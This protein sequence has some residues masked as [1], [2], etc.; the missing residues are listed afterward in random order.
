MKVPA[1]LG[2]AVA[3]VTGIFG[4]AANQI[5]ALVVTLLAARWLTPITF[6]EYSIAA[7]LITLSRA[8]LYA[9]AYEFLLKAP[10]GE[11][12]NTECLIVNVG[13]AAGLGGL[14][15]LLALF[16]GAIFHSTEVGFLLVVLAPSS[17]LSAAANW[18][19]AQML[20]A[21]RIKTYYGVT[22]FAEVAAA[23]VTI[24]MI[25]LGFGLGALVA[26]I[27]CRLFTLMVTYRV[28]Q[29]PIWSK[30][31]SF[32]RVTH[33]GRWSLHRYGATIVSFLSN[34]SADI[35]L[36]VFLSPAAT[37][38]YRASHR[39]V[40][41]VSDLISNPTRMTAITIF[42]RR[43][44]GNLDSGALWP[45]IAAASAMLGWA[46]LAGLAAISSQIV[47]LVLGA[48]WKAAAPVIAILCLQR[49]F[50]LVDGVTAPML[51]AYNYVRELLAI[52]VVMA[53]TSVM[54]LA[55]MARYGVGAAAWSSVITAGASMWVCATLA[56]RKFPGLLP[57]LPG[58]LPVA[59]GP[60]LATGTTAF[61]LTLFLHTGGAR[62][63][64]ALALEVAAGLG[65][66][67][68]AVFA[69]RGGVLDV[70]HSLNPPAKP[71]HGNDNPIHVHASVVAR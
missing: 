4:R 61:A 16:T 7:A 18:Q 56:S 59:L 66:F 62:D 65:A 33:I 46:A 3:A 45:K 17:L 5:I 60:P 32:E 38:L 40:T 48:R 51:V 36:G 35:L 54:L 2:G 29:K 9:G 8:M 25:L 57:K 42:S 49:A 67:A 43:A 63:L 52:Q 41:G 11:E 31:I 34:Y 39:V 14:L 20:R 15:G 19:E 28:L 64:A 50:T 12:S 23:I 26:Q 37:G 24:T 22:T 47:P 30:T 69:L 53:I 10:V 44:G 6:G 27:Y 13:L 58:V 21:G 71:G 68:V 1:S 70:L 55:V